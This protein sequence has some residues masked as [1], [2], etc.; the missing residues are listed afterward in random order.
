MLFRLFSERD[1]GVDGVLEIFEL[2]E[3]TGKIALIQIKGTNSKID[4]LKTVDYVS[5]PGISKSSLKYCSVNKIP[6]ILVYVSKK[7]ELFYY[8][9]LHS[10]YEES[11]K[12]MG[13]TG[14]TCSI[15]IPY[16]Y[17]SNKLDTLVTIINSYYSENPDSLSQGHIDYEYDGIID[18]TESLRNQFIN[19]VVQNKVQEIIRI[20][21]WAGFNPELILAMEQFRISV[22]GIIDRAV[23]ISNSS[24]YKRITDFCDAYNKYIVFL[25][26][27]CLP[28]SN[29]ELSISCK[30]DNPK[31]IGDKIKRLTNKANRLLHKAMI[32]DNS[33]N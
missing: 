9:D 18:T 22:T 10:V 12:R 6:F 2:G 13:D 15:R 28:K 19:A 21:Y 23:S 24:Q 32:Q 31:K 20:D 5:C 30:F 4:K 8:C 14:K 26:D 3:T 33:I 16:I 7:D 11:L 29:G 25:E 17:N 27:N 1:Y